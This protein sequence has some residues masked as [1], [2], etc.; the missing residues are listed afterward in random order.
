MSYKSS[1]FIS[2]LF[3]TLV[4]AGCGDATPVETEP[5][6]EQAAYETLTGVIRPLGVSIYQE[7]THRLDVGGQLAAL[8]TTSSNRIHLENY[9]GDTVD[10]QGIIRPSVEGNIDVMQVVAV[11]PLEVA[12]TGEVSYETFADAEYGFSVMYPNTLSA[13]ESRTGASFHDGETKIIEIAVLENKLARELTDYLIDQ[14]GYAADQL[15]RISVGGIAGYQFENATG[16]VM[17]LGQDAQIFALAWLDTDAD[18][19]ARNKRYYLELVQ[20]FSFIDESLAE[21]VPGKQLAALGEFCGGIAAVRCATGLSCRY[22][23]QYPDAGGTCM[24]AETG[25]GG[26]GVAAVLSADTAANEELPAVSEVEAF[27]GWYYGELDSKKPDTPDDWL[28]VDAGTRFAMWRRPDTL[29]EAEAVLTETTATADALS[30]D[31][32]TVFDHVR[33]NIA[34]IAPTAPTEGSWE[35]IQQA[36]AAPNYAYV[37]YKSAEQTRKLLLVY[38]VQGDTVTLEP[39]GYFRPGVNRDWI[40]TEGV[41]S[42]FGKSLAVVDAT[43]KVAT[44][45]LEGLREYKNRHIG[46]SLQYPKNWYWQNVEEGRA[47]EFSDLPFPRGLVRIR[48][49]I[50]DG[51]DYYFDELQPSEEP[52]GR[53]IYIRFTP[54]QSMLISGDKEYAQQ[55]Q[56]MVLTFTK[57]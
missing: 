46:Y 49:E 54:E 11:T 28:L 23:A 25:E 37:V 1:F 41:D 22:D 33:A 26:E 5:A 48:T 42:A 3:G 14:Y 39:T 31:Q 32:R 2:M 38:T 24:A 34:S 44:T 7:G 35:V 29:P 17:Y 57:S 55:M 10:V 20:S 8:L 56:Q 19:R 12:S 15:T 16:T 18:Q 13:R 6:E 47:V 50:V 53:Q 4:L 52:E 9:I 40:T 30:K 45:I 27:R 36:F 21:L 43:G 51:A